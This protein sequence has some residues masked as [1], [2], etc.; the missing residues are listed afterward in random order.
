MFIG[1]LG[2]F[3]IY[4]LNDTS[5]PTQAASKQVCHHYGNTLTAGAMENIQCDGVLVAR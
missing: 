5:D 4:G 1:G 2:N 3:T